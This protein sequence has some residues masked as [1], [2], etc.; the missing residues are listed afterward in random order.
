M[1]T[2]TYTSD[3][4]IGGKD[5]TTFF[6]GA[7]PAP[8]SSQNDGII[9]RQSGELILTCFKADGTT[10]FDLTSLGTLDAKI[11]PWNSP[12]SPV[13]LGTGV[14]SGAG[15]NIYT[16]TWAKDTI[17]AN[18]SSFA[19]DREGTIALLIELDET[20]DDYFQ[21][22]TRFNVT[23][24]NLAGD[25]SSE[26]TG[27][28]DFT[29]SP[30]N[31]VDWSKFDQGT[32]ISV[33]G[34]LDV[35]AQAGKTDWGHVISRTEVTAPASPTNGDTYVIA[36]IGGDWSTFAINDIVRS[37]GTTWT[38]KTP[39][40]GDEVYDGT[41]QDRYRF[42]SSS[43]IV[44]D[45]DVTGPA[46]AI[47]D[48]IC[49][50]DSTTGKL[51]QDSGIN[52]SDVI[53]N[54]LKVTSA[55]NLIVDGQF[56]HWDDGAGPFTA[57]GYFPTIWRVNNTGN[58]GTGWQR[59]DFT[60]GQTDVPHN[61]KYFMSCNNVSSATINLFTRLDLLEVTADTEVTFSV[62]LR[63]ASGSGNVG[64][65][66]NQNF[67]T[68]GSPS[69]AV[70]VTN[71]AVTPSG[72]WTKFSVTVGLP[73]LSGKT[74]GT[75]GN[76]RI[77]IIIDQDFSLG[78]FEGTLEYANLS[79][80]YGSVAYDQAYPT[81]A[82]ER[83]R[84]DEYY[85]IIGDYDEGVAGSNQSIRLNP[86]Q[87][88]TPAVTRRTTETFRRVMR[89]IPTI[90]VPTPNNGTTGSITSTK[91]SVYIISSASSTSAEQAISHIIA[92]ARL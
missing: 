19:S 17:P 64:L 55:Q 49:T 75:D 1:D 36:G 25:E 28:F 40:E 11:V 67:G 89:A 29:Y 20:G 31:S 80:V 61:P 83:H 57:S 12:V 76:S 7:F 66:M 68:G 91:S 72:T 59:G 88:G 92:D 22:Y 8:S 2:P 79:L 62:W 23:D 33:N 34:A 37:D 5:Q 38:N 26:P 71:S 63:A 50:F 70:L 18:Y 74:L 85:Q 4:I 43:W 9:T 56:N 21:V 86:D 82:E 16:V 90:T 81:P 35:L 84:I 54:S 48:N 32:P 58:S 52:I 46:V 44:S 10:A 27:G 51:I 24:G 15:N 39:I 60:L 30:A 47:D 73:S 65:R 87:A 78:T 53:A 13:V 3:I 14:I 6:P 42:D 45:G 77:E 69:T 41:D